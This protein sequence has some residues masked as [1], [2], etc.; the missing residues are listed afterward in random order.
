M[1]RTILHTIFK[2][3]LLQLLLCAASLLSPLSTLHC[4]LGEDGTDCCKQQNY[5]Q[6]TLQI[7]FFCKFHLNFLFCVAKIRIFFVI[8]QAKLNFYII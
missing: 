8:L 3:R 5:G 1:N 4:N 6:K 2:Y 7:S